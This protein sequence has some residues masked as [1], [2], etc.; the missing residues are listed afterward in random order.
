MRAVEH[1]WHLWFPIQHWIAVHM[2]IGTS[3]RA[4]YWYSF[5]SGSGSNL[6]LYASVLLLAKAHLN[7]HEPG[8]LRI[9]KHHY[10][11]VAGV[12]H[13]LCIKHHPTHPGKGVS[14]AEH[15]AADYAARQGDC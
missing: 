6:G 7:C 9:A 13:L 11:D 1:L 15:C 5:H 10:Y 14:I 3:P 4:T 2:G 12:R 8:C